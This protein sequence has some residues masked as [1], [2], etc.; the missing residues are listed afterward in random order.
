MKTIP[1]FTKPQVDCPECKGSRFYGGA[2][3]TRDC[4]ECRGFGHVDADP[5]PIDWSGLRK[6]EK[7]KDQLAELDKAIQNVESEIKRSMNQ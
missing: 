4:F 6:A 2:F 3:G 1:G 5:T 7:A